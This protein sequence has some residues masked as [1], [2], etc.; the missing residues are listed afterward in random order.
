MWWV[1]AGTLSAHVPDRSALEVLL[2]VASSGGLNG[3]ARQADA[4]GGGAARAPAALSVSTTVAVPAA[5]L[6][7]RR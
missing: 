1:A 2:G 5:D 3:T 4:L 6:R 7:S